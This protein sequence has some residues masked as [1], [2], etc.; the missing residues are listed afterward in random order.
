MNARCVSTP[1]PVA[2]LPAILLYVAGSHRQ[3][4]IVAACL[5]QEVQASLEMPPSRQAHARYAPRHARIRYAAAARQERGEIRDAGA[6]ASTRR[7]RRR[8]RRLIRAGRGQRARAAH[9]Y[10]RQR[11][12]YI[13]EK[14]YFV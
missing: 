12:A 13:V 10:E 11:R 8:A 7:Y 5:L 1:M 4:S 3:R 6:A 2:A 14:R 9:D